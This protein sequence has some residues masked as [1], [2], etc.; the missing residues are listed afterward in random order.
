MLATK[1]NCAIRTDTKS[2]SNGWDHV[3]DA[4]PQLEGDAGDDWSVVVKVENGNVAMKPLG[5]LKKNILV[6]SWEWFSLS[7]FLN[8]K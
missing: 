8:K 5:G 3:E 4:G 7:I 6:P 1:F 2:S